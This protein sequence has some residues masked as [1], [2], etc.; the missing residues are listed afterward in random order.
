MFAVV[1]RSFLFSVFIFVF[2]Y[3]PTNKQSSI[4]SVSNWK[5]QRFWM[6][7][8]TY[9]RNCRRI[10]QCV[11]LTLANIRF[12]YERKPLARFICFDSIHTQALS[13]MFVCTRLIPTKSAQWESHST[14]A[15]TWRL[16]LQWAVSKNLRISPNICQLSWNKM[17]SFATGHMEV[18]GTAEEFSFPNRGHPHCLV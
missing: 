17:K 6:R 15:L 4:Q 1:F 16:M 12:S 3:A 10:D 7:R 8:N 9:D 2:V 5:K 18:R 14:N 11:T 13:F